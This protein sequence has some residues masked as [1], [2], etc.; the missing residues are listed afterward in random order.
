MPG[1]LVCEDCHQKR[2]VNYGLPSEGRKWR[3]CAKCAGKHAGA[4]NVRNK[5]CETCLKMAA[6]HGLIKGGKKWCTGCSKAQPGAVSKTGKCCDD[7]GQGP[8]EAVSVVFGQH[9]DG[10]RKWCRPC[11]SKHGGAFI[12]QNPCEVCGKTANFGM[13]AERRMRW[14]GGCSKHHPGAENIGQKKCEDCHKKHPT[15]G[16]ELD[17]KRRW[18][19][20]CATKGHPGSIAI[21]SGRV[22]TDCA[23]KKPTYGIPGTDAKAVRIPPPQDH[24]NTC[25][26]HLLRRF[27]APHRFGRAA[28]A[29]G[30]P[31]DPR[32]S[33]QVWCATCARS[34]PGAKDMVSQLCQGCHNVAPSYGKSLSRVVALLP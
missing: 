30:A 16:M 34:H 1:K 24:N 14:C 28:A 15:F 5:Q 26:D 2:Y 9:E 23:S 29:A 3:W 21:V 18:C 13:P 17:K 27:P 19:K 10:K 25:R 33:R 32:N 7:C 6:T 22:C 31:A 8:N 12:P 11:A 4:R 20:L